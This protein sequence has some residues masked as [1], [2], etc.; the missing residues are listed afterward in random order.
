M[1]TTN[2]L[3]LAAAGVLAASSLGAQAIDF[4][5]DGVTVQGG[6]GSQRSASLG[7]GVVWDWKE[8]LWERV[9]ELEGRTEFLV[10]TWR[11]DDIGGGSQHFTQLVLLPTLRWRFRDGGSRWV[12]EL[13]VG[14]SWMDKL[15]VTPDKA[16]STQWNFYD[17]LGLAYTLGGPDGRQEVGVRIVHVSN[18]S[19]K[20]PNPGQDFVQLRYVARF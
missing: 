8:P 16:F 11:A 15:Y 3:R 9:P 20:Q 19:T 12:V 18:C 14:A 5:P 7:V 10:N 2:I 1:T 6:P 4:T 17:V 13:G